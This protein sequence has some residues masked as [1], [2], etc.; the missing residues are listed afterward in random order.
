MTCWVRNRSRNWSDDFRRDFRSTQLQ[1]E[2]SPSKFL[3][4]KRILPKWSNFGKN[5]VNAGVANHTGRY[6]TID[7]SWL[8]A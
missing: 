5:F 6:A 7:A 2:K 8:K 4:G 3:G 1:N